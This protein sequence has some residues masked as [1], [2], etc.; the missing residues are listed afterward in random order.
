MLILLISQKIERIYPQNEGEIKKKEIDK[1]YKTDSYFL[2]SRSYGIS[3]YLT[4][5]HGAS[6]PGDN[7][8]NM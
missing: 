6:N 3:Q 8:T 7:T 4:R 5:K 2:W 1:Y